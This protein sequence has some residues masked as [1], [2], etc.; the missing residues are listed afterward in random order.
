[1]TLQT[2]ASLILMCRGEAASPPGL[3]LEISAAVGERK[4]RVTAK[5][6]VHFLCPTTFSLSLLKRDIRWPGKL[7]QHGIRVVETTQTIRK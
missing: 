2:V 6:P 1:M 7:K 4:S 5:S 3:K